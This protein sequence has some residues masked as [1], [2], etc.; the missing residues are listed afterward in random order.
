MHH[1]YNSI[2]TYNG[3]QKKVHAG[4]YT[5]KTT[6][7]NHLHARKSSESVLYLGVATKAMAAALSTVE[8]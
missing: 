8:K 6:V 3:F 2:N 4:R 5:V 7:F 1:T